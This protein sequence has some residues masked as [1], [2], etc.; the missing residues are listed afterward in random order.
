MTE[1]S[2]GEFINFND[3]PIICLFVR[4]NK[5]ECSLNPTDGKCLEILEHGKL[6]E[7][8]YYHF[9][10]SVTPEFPGEN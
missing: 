7:L 10:F 9:I 4:I 1:R 6:L 2:K 5:E 3:S 8:F